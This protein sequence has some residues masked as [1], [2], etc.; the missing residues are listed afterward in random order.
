MPSPAQ[1]D[2]F[3]SVDAARARA[4][5]AARP[6]RAVEWVDLIDA[7]GRIAAADNALVSPLPPFDNAAMDG[8]A[9]RLADCRPDQATR[10]PVVE[11]VA[12]GDTRRVM[13]AAGTAARIFTGAPIP[14]GADAVIMQEHVTRHGDEIEMTGPL[15]A[16]LNIRRAGEDQ[17]SGCA[18]IPAGTLLTPPRLALLA[19]GGLT[20][21]RVFARL[22]VGLFST[23]N[24]L[25]EPGEA[26]AHGQIYNSNRVMLR[27]L[28]DRPWVRLN[29]YGILRDHPTLIRDAISLAAAENDIVVS[30]GGISVGE[31][32]HVRAALGAG[33][34]AF[35]CL[36]VA[37][38]PG[39]PLTIGHVG[40]ALYIGLPGNPYAA[41]ITCTQIALP[42]LRRAAGIT[43][44]DDRM[45]PGVADFT[46]HRRPGRTEY[47]PVAWTARDALGRPKLI[48]LGQG[49]SASLSP[50]ALAMGIAALPPDLETINPGDPL[51]VDPLG[52]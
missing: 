45:I 4:V 26:L 6:L 13:L 37:I 35:E 32:D 21:V 40:T 12:A 7:R 31:E 16:G 28:L 22:R 1:L 29:D 47:V 14:E 44:V 19:G 49:A 36:N 42:T 3:L 27:A 20:R 33:G 15:R 46:Y 50:F 51:P 30:S 5:A 34:G 17:P 2:P 48:R 9:I 52:A 18:A 25:R 11:R 39:K 41:A 10:L 23:G 24:E 38:R 43:E 8:Y